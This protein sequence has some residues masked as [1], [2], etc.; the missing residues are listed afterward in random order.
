V[1]V[2]FQP[3]DHALGPI[4]VDLAEAAATRL[5]LAHWL[6][7]ILLCADDLAADER[8][9]LEL[10]RGEAGRRLTVYLHPDAVLKD[11]TEVPG[12]AA[13]REWE[14]RP[15]ARQPLPWRSADFAVQKA[16]RLLYRQFLLARDVCDGT[17]EPRE[18]PVSL[19]EAFQEAWSVGLDGRLRREGLPG[20]SE[21]ESRNRFLRLF[22]TSGV[23]TPAHWQV[24]HALWE[25]TIATQGEVLRSV[26]RLPPLRR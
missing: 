16:Q 23:V 10:R 17:L 22:A 3:A 2:A 9:W 7:A 20:L 8:A 1:I 25:G 19:A 6:E 13:T 26:R 24:F 12:Q 14:L 15:V 4:L 18:I 5:G 21:G 11:R